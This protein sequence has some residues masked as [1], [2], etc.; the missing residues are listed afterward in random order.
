MARAQ[1]V[2]ARWRQGVSHILHQQPWRRGDGDHLE[3]PRHHAA[4]P[5]GDLG[6]LAGGLPPDPAVQ[7]VELAR[8]LRRRTDTSPEMGRYFD[9]PSRSRYSKARGRGESELKKPLPITIQG[10]TDPQV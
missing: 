6:G 5:S 2:L 3:L 9:R 10:F 8:Q 1:R 4:R 7:V